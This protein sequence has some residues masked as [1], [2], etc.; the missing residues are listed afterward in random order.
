MIPITTIIASILAPLLFGYVAYNE[1]DK[2]MI[3]NKLER[4]QET[5]HEVKSEAAVLSSR[6]DDVKEDLKRIEKKLDALLE[7]LINRGNQ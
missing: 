4:A 7:V 2:I 1:R 6:Q 3:K 5:V